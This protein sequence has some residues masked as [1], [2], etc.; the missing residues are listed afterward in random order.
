MKEAWI[1]RLSTGWI[2]N[3]LTWSNH[4]IKVVDTYW[5]ELIICLEDWLIQG[6]LAEDSK[7]AYDARHEIMK[8]VHTHVL[9]HIHTDHGGWYVTSQAV[10]ALP[11]NAK[12]LCP[13]IVKQQSRIVLPVWFALQQREEWKANGISKRIA[14][15]HLTLNRLERLYQDMNDKECFEMND[16]LFHSQN[17]WGSSKERIREKK[18]EKNNNKKS[19]LHKLYKWVKDNYNLMREWWIKD[20]HD[21]QNVI[22]QR[23]NH[24]DVN[25]Q[26]LE[27]IQ[28]N[29]LTK[30]TLKDLENT[31]NKFIWIDFDVPHIISESPKVSITFKRSNHMLWASMILIETDLWTML[32]TWDVPRIIWNRFLPW[33]DYRI[34]KTIDYLLMESTYWNRLHKKTYEQWVAEL[35]NI[36]SNH[37]PWSYSLIVNISSRGPEIGCI[38][39]EEIIRNKSNELLNILWRT[40]QEFLKLAIQHWWNKYNL[41][42]THKDKY[43][44]WI[45]ASENIIPWIYMST[46]WFLAG[47]S[48]EM[49]KSIANDPNSQIIFT[50]YVP[51]SMPWY[52][53]IHENII[54]SLDGT[55]PI[56]FLWKVYQIDWL[57]GHGDQSDLLNFRKKLGMPYTELVHGDLEAKAELKLKMEQQPWNKN[58][59]EIAEWM[60]RKKVI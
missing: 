12:I 10:W 8:K 35:Q 57:S 2:G 55:E 28:L 41:Y 5:R 54:D 53:L 34:N 32:Y 6:S 44:S 38:T 22:S 18:F 27:S 48:L 45:F 37:K 56:P 7:K 26:K 40:N 25:K 21:V 31:L 30:W 60:E 9:S 24:I 59:V 23:K 16:Y 17:D 49:A 15:E 20:V 1:F 39:L 19:N 36:I 43:V 50:S 3:D 4:L 29:A 58:K 33:P 51:K 46:A 11:K 42:N 52:R 14:N 47:I 13:H